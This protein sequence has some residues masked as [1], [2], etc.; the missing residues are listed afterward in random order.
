MAAIPE[1][2][3]HLA[4]SLVEAGREI[5]LPTSRE[6]VA[7]EN[8]LERGFDPVT[9]A[10]RECEARLRELIAARYPDHAI[11]GEELDERPGSARWSWSLDPIDGTRGFICGIPVW[12]TL[13]ALLE[14]GEPVLGL[15]DVPRLD[16][17][18]IGHETKA[19][20]IGAGVS[21][22]I[23]TS[24]CTSLGEARL[25]TTDPNLFT[26]SEAEAFERLRQRV[27][28]TR[29]GLDAYGYAL[30]A[31][32]WLDL[33]VESGLKPH[34]YNALIPVV[35]AAGGTIGDWS[36]GEDFSE[37]RLVAAATRDLYEQ[38]VEALG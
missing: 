32:G 17:T 23:A 20:L 35:R 14:E 22:N 15:I 25:S 24:R 1:D 7:V 30:V 16:E 27:R 8:K 36:G 18:Y 34:D 33:V 37:G 6:G 19:E 38:A 11:A 5:T 21:R 31:A 13:I 26:G 4:R 9:R 28:V 10:D 3:L 29:Y 2:L 12:T